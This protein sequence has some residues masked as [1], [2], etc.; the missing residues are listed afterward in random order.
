MKTLIKTIIMAL[1]LMG[2]ALACKLSNSINSFSFKLLNASLNGKNLNLSPYSIYI[3]FSPVYE[4]AENNTEK[5]LKLGFLYHSKIELRKLLKA[6]ITEKKEN[7]KLYNGIYIQKGF[8]IRQNYLKAVKN[9]YKPEIS[10]VDFTTK[11]G[12]KKT[13][14]RINSNVKNTT[15]GKIKDLIKQTDITPLTRLIIVNAIHFKDRWKMPFKKE[16][17]ATKPFHS[18]NG[19]VKVPTMET[20]GRF[21]IFENKTVKAVSLPYE[22]GYK[23]LIFLPKKGNFKLTYNTYKNIIRKMKPT[24]IK[25]EMPKFTTENRIYL[26][27]TLSKLGVKDVFTMKANLSRITGKKNLYV[28][29]AIHQTFIHVDENGTEAAAATAVAIGL[30]SIPPKRKKLFKIDRPFFFTLTDKKGIILFTGY[31]VNPLEE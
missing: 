24:F 7:I 14:Y 2:S 13:I 19:T 23:M 25:I 17:T 21:A 30:K 27:S 3:A 12:R 22:N 9:F 8:Y 5:E 1:L 11:D 29:K 10:S 18:V 15:E 16:L 31:I 6:E 26:K 20:T 4:G 28:Q